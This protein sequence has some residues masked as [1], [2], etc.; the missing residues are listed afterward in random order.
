MPSLAKTLPLAALMAFGVATIAE[1][2]PDLRKMTCA[3]AQNMVRKHGAVVFTTGPHTY[4][5]FVG[6][7]GYC[8]G[9]ERLFPRYSATRDNP[10]CFVAYECREPLFPLW[11]D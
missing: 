10:Q 2:R 11:G 4:D 3:Q 1:A 5:K 9:L 6:H 8:E 7:R